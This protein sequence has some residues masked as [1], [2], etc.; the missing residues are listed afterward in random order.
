MLI[1]SLL[2]TLL[3][4]GQAFAAPPPPKAAPYQMA[5]FAPRRPAVVWSSLGEATVGGRRNPTAT[6]E[7]DRGAG[8]LSK[9]RLMVRE[10]DEGAM[11]VRVTFAN[12]RDLVTQVSGRMAVIDLPGDARAVRTIE[13]SSPRRGY[14]YGHGFGFGRGQRTTVEVFGERAAMNFPYAMR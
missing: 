9:L 2:A 14:G 3:A 8:R 7:L 1:G 4:G 5:R 13:L 11:Q 12:G 10:G 6:I